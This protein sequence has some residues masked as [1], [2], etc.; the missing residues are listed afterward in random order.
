MGDNMRI[1]IVED[2]YSLAEIIETRLKKEKYEVDIV[3][4]G[5]EGLFNALSGAYNL[6]ILDVMLPH[7]DGFEILKQIRENKIDTKIIMLTAKSELDDKLSGFKYGA[8]DYVTKPF[9]IEELIARVNVQL[10]K[11]KNKNITDTIEVFDLHLNLKKALLECTSTNDSIEIS[12]KEFYNSK[13]ILNI[14][15]NILVCI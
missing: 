3:T 13:I 11:D 12:N 2:E 5:E 10:R 15:E 1:L 8:D 7:L 14:L 6:V 4:D 9:H